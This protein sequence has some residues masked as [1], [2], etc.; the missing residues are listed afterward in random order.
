MARASRL[1]MWAFGGLA[2]GVGLAFL[3]L[4]L[5]ARTRPGHEFVLQ[6]TLKALGKSIHGGRLTIHRIEGNLFE[7][8]KIYGLSLRQNNGE[9]FIVA[10]SAFAEYDVKTL[11]TP[12][13]V[14]DR[15]TLYDPEIYV[16]KLPGDTLWNY[17]RI[18]SDTATTSDTS[19]VKVER[20]VQAAFVRL[21]NADVR[22]ETP[23]R[24]DS[25]LPAR[26]RRRI[27]NAAL[28]DT[29]AVM[30]RRVKGGYVRTIRLTGVHGG[31]SGIRFAPGSERGSRFG[32]DSLAGTVQFYRT[33]A[34]ITALRGQIA[35][36]RDHVEFDAPLL[37]F[38]NSRLTASGVIRT[39]GLPKWVDPPEGPAYDV[40]FAGDSIALRDFRW[41]YARFPADAR[42]S[43]RLMVET[44]PGGTMLLARDADVRAPGTRIRGSF[45]MLMGDT[46]R[47][48]DVDLE[49]RPLR[50]SFIEKL[51]PDGLP[52]RGLVLGGV[53]IRGNNAA[54][55]RPAE[56]EDDQEDGEAPPAE[57][58]A[59]APARPAART[60]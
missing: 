5:V 24:A 60:R 7:G 26:E 4:N 23:F 55:S 11:L 38:P 34:R 17:Q 9:A 12:R 29:G 8:A 57:R 40:A 58:P 2:V 25:T 13:I 59:S 30:A 53:E 39:A 1:A 16:Y 35:L 46:L 33:P 45:G 22:V 15:L 6:Q 28:S 27:L 19:T 42:G 3:L 44:R 41:I 20:V 21:V 51:L 32:I 43:L 14:I 10:D 56:E 49:L 18:F 37:R 47:F 31:L 50:T 36:F 52:V 54:A 48:N